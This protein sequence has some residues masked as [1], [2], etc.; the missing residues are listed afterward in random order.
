MAGARGRAL[1]EG[2]RC[3]LR[4]RRC[5]ERELAGTRASQ[6]AGRR[7]CDADVQEE[8]AA[9]ACSFGLHNKF[10]FESLYFL[11]WPSL[12]QKNLDL[13]KSNLFR[14]PLGISKK[15]SIN[16][17]RLVS[18]E[19]INTC[20]SPYNGILPIQLANFM[21]KLSSTGLYSQFVSFR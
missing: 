11:L 7:R 3:E 14:T 1:R 4:G 19:L 21:S 2:T 9:R 5:D 6:A 13:K 20:M 15:E 18:I 10:H 16:I 17:G 12:C 8:A